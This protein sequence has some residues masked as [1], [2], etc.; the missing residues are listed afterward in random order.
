[1]V[2]VLGAKVVQ[3]ERSAKQKTIFLFA[4]P[5]RSLPSPKATVV[6]VEHNAKKKLFFLALSKRSLPSPKARPYNADVRLFELFL[7]DHCRRRACICCFSVSS[8]SA[9]SLHAHRWNE[10]EKTEKAENTM[11][12]SRYIYV[13][14]YIFIYLYLLFVCVSACDDTKTFFVSFR[15]PFHFVLY[16]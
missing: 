2:L 4:I 13:Y 12:V 11:K 9:L 3:V 8:V 6:Q 1:M 5:K 14:I 10:T 15:F 16:I 7:K